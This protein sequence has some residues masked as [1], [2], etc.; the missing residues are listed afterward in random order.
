MSLEAGWGGVEDG[1][2]RPLLQVWDGPAIDHPLLDGVPWL[3]GGEGL[4][5][6]TARDRGGNL[7][8]VE[9]DTDALIRVLS[10]GR[11][12]V[13]PPGLEP[14]LFSCLEAGL[15]TVLWDPRLR[16]A[17]KAAGLSWAPERAEVVQQELAAAA[18][19]ARWFL[20]LVDEVVRR[21]RE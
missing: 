7:A 21:I 18:E 13:A 3:G 11:L 4:A 6:A 14:E 19:G 12:F 2:I 1:L 10:A 15:H 20:P 17:A 5:L 8:K 9:A 16:E